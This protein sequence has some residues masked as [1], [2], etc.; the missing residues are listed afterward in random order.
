MSGSDWPAPVRQGR[1]AAWL[2]WT[3]AAVSG[4]GKCA[5]PTVAEEAPPRARPCMRLG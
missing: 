4:A 5:I 1:T 3:S 2:G